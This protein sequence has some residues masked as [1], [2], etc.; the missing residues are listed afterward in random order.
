M[1]VSFN[2]GNLLN[3]NGI[4]VKSVVSAFLAPSNASISI[5]QN[6]QTNLATN[7]GLLQGINNNLTNLA[8]A[9]AA[10]ADPQGALAAIAATSTVPSILTATGQA[11][12]VTGS[13]Q[14]VV[15][16]LATTGTLFTNPVTD[17]NTSFLT[18][19]ATTGD[20]QLQVGG[21]TGK[22]LDIAITKGSNDTLSTLADYINKQS[23]GVTASVVTDAT[24]ARLTLLSKASG[25]PGALAITN[26]TT[27]LIFNTP[28]GGTNAQLTIDGVPFASATNTV[29]GAIPGV[30]LNLASAAPGT[31]VQLTVG[32]DTAQATAAINNFVSAYNAIV[33]NL[34][35]QFAVDPT[36][37]AQGPLAPDTSL[38]SV[39][40][41]NPS[42][43]QS[44]FQNASGTGFANNLNTNLQGL[45][46]PTAGI[47]NV[48]IAGNTT[49]QSALT[50][51][52]ASLQDRVTAQT[53][54]LTLL[55]DKVN[56]TLESYPILLQETT[57]EIAAINGNTIS[58]PSASTNTAPTKG[59]ATGS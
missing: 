9:A 36:T 30:T 14:I 32:P 43:V 50:K 34:N 35:A 33:G 1:G 41:A 16:S 55:Y 13:H 42:G 45:T 19:G 11:S 51:Q 58:Q 20:I 48:D 29:T 15:S 22:T 17:G 27:G 46:D 54:S 8:T 18:A 2:A 4:D 40:A 26:N 21:P 44:F 6:Q 5:Y 37:N 56:A 57:A 12:A 28:V 53:A 31:P 38:S 25:T 47:L 3:G 24:G 23:F 7:A 52:I 10:L 59:V 49:Q 39:L